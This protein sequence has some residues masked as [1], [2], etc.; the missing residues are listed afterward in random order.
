MLYYEPLAWARGRWN[1]TL[2]LHSRNILYLFIAQ[3]LKSTAIAAGNYNEAK[4][5]VANPNSDA[6]SPRALYPHDIA[7]LTD[8][9]IQQIQVLWCNLFVAM[10][11]EKLTNPAAQTHTSRSSLPRRSSERKKWKDRTPSFRGQPQLQSDSQE[12]L[13]REVS[14][15]ST[16]APSSQRV[17]KERWWK[18]RLFRG[19]INDIKRR[20]PYYVSDWKDA[21]DYRVVP[22]TIYM[23]FAKYA[24]RWT[25]NA[26]LP[27]ALTHD[28]SVVAMLLFPISSCSI[29]G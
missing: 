1:Y 10:P 24:P 14:H 2:L 27:S 19:M 18:V 26:K 15:A 4:E 11:T 6:N 16:H 29:L 23:Y 13:S 25:D 3:L 12:A 7:H 20:A 8:Y 22:A 28:G 9:V 21:W 5:A 17:S